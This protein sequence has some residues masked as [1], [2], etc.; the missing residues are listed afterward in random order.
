M[1]ERVVYREY[2]SWAPWVYVVLWGAVIGSAAGVFLGAD[3][4]LPDAGRILA[5][6]VILGVGALVQRLLGGLTVRLTPEAVQVG[7]GRGWP[8]RTRIPYER[9]ASLE[10]VTYRPLGEFG[11]WGLRGFGSRQAWTARGNRAVVLHLVDLRDIYVGSDNPRRLE[12]RIR[13]TAGTRL[14][15][16]RSRA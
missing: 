15:G 5:A 4:V 2:T 3:D 9:I 1:D 11:G 6:S 16:A 8:L 13:A 7:L 10:T 14:G 12:E